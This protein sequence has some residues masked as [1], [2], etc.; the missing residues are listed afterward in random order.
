MF[1]FHGM[2]KRTLRAGDP[3]YCHCQKTARLV[4]ERLALPDEQWR[5]TFQSRFGRAEWLQ[6]YTDKT[7]HKWAGDGVKRVDVVCPGFAADCLETLEEI[8]ML[9]K[10]AFLAAGGERLHYI[11]ALNDRSDHIA[12]LADL[13]GEHICGWPEAAPSHDEARTTAEAQARLRRA[14]ALGAEQ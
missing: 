8:A 13:L 11:P 2:P 4:A 5:L 7:L 1:S 14:Q 3:Y 6:P 10:D 9:N 12:A